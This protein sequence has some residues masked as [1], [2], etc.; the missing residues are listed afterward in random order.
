MSSAQKGA[1]LRRKAGLASA[2]RLFVKD[3]VACGHV[4]ALLCDAKE[5]FGAC[6]VPGLCGFKGLLCA[7]LHL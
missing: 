6:S 7:S 2:G 4:D 1:N 3:T 5:F